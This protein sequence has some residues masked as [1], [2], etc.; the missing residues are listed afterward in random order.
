MTGCG[1]DG[2]DLYAV[3]YVEV[4]WAEVEAWKR[5]EERVVGNVDGEAD[6]EGEGSEV[7]GNDSRIDDLKRSDGAHAPVRT[8]SPPLSLSS[9]QREFDTRIRREQAEQK[10]NEERVHNE[11]VTRVRADLEAAEIRRRNTASLASV[12]A[13]LRKSLQ[14][15]RSGFVAAQSA[16]TVGETCDIPP[17]WSAVSRAML[18]Q[19]PHLLTE[20]FVQEKE[21]RDLLYNYIEWTR[22]QIQEHGRMDAQVFEVLE[23]LNKAQ[24]VRV[25]DMEERGDEMLLRSMLAN[26]TALVLEQKVARANGQAVDTQCI[27]ELGSVLKDAVAE[28]P[29]LEIEHEGLVALERRHFPERFHL[30]WICRRGSDETTLLSSGMSCLA[31]RCTNGT[32]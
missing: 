14:A 20:Y 23:K 11:L 30:R 4:S 8:P 22:T 1:C 13:R 24:Q 32:C 27:S 17:P 25:T 29:H 15:R 9:D 2:D 28:Y 6:G 19:H 5:E 10:A 3:D 21:I 12:E 7:D 16:Y 31:E 26:K 18:L